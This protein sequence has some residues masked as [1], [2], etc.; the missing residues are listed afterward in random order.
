MG[1]PDITELA[2]LII[3]GTALDEASLLGL[4]DAPLDELCEAACQIRDACCG[5][6]F[7][8]CTIMN[9]KSGRCSENCRFC[10]QSAHWSTNAPVHGFSS[11]EEI[12][13]HARRDAQSGSMRFSLV[14]SGEHV[15]AR[16]VEVAC[17]AARRIRQETSLE[18][19]A[20]LGLL[21]REDYARLHEAGVTRIHNNLET[22][23]SH[24]GSICTTH[25]Y[26]SKICALKAARAAG[27]EVCSGGI[28]GMGET[29]EQRVEL[30]CELRALNVRSVPI[31][32][33]NPIAGTPLQDMEPLGID[34]VRRTFAIFRFAL[35]AAALR[36]AGG[37][38]LL[39]GAGRACLHAGANAAISGDMLTTVGFTVASDREMI[40]EEGFVPRKLG[41]V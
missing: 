35:P 4:V 20:S 33:L 10:A 41:E 17:E 29:W 22:A 19:C 12:V 38:I 7:E 26:D 11:V 14:A 28:I 13:A 40:V 16:D 34:E 37:R 32:V 15:S 30:A 25:A 1:K 6:G 5:S 8:L 31:N 18:V 36:L 9:V 2:S 27:L 24:F 3:K 39:P 23:R 21:G